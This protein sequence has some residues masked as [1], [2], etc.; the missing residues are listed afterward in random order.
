MEIIRWYADVFNSDSVGGFGNANAFSITCRALTYINDKPHSHSRCANN[1]K[2]S[3]YLAFCL[4]NANMLFS[5]SAAVTASTVFI[6]HC[7][8]V[9]LRT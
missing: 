7:A 2:E 6:S 8:S 4:L 9:E 5:C 1:I 3:D